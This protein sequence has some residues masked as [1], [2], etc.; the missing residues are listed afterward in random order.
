MLRSLLLWLLLGGLALVAHDAGTGG[1]SGAPQTVLPDGGTGWPT[2][3]AP[4][5]SPSP[6]P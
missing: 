3:G 2:P 5:P 1:P 4:T 6:A